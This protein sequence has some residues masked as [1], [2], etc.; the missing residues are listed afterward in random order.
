MKKSILCALALVAQLFATQPINAQIPIDYVW[1]TP[2]KNSSESM[3]CGGGSVGMNVWVENGTIFFY[4]CR[5]GSFD[6][7]NTILK[8]GRFRINLIPALKTDANFSQILHLSDGYVSVSDGE[9]TV[10]IWVDVFKPVIHVDIDGKQSLKV[11]ASYDNWRIEDKQLGDRER[12]QTSYK[13]SAPKGT[14]THR[15]SISA[16]KQSITFFHH[17]GKLT[18]FDATVAQQKMESV[19]TIMYN[20]LKNLTFGGEM[21]GNGFFLKGENKGVYADTPY[22]T[23]IYESVNAAK[24]QQLQITLASA[25][26]DI[27]QWKNE[28]EKT[29]TA[30]N[31]KKDK[32]ITRKWWKQYWK[33]SVI[34]G[35]GECAAITR[36]YTLF[37][38][39]LGCNAISEWPTKF[40]GGLLAFD[41]VY[42][43]KNNHFTPDYRNWGGGVHTM[44]N[45]RLVYWP[46]LKSG[47]Y[48][49]MK[50][51]FDFYLR[52]LGNAQLRSNVYWNHKGAAFTEQMENFGL[53]NFDEYGKKR[54]VGYDPGIQYNAWL[55]YTWDTALE[56]CEMILESE[57]YSN[58]NISEYIP[59]V[60]S[61]L[62]FFDEHY[63]YLAKLRGIKELDGDGK[64][65]IYPGSGAE[66]FKMAYNPTSTVAG[67]KVVTSSLI[68]YL[69]KHNS[70]SIS[71]NKYKE[72]LQ[73]IPDI[74]FREVDGHKILSPAVTWARVNNTEPTELYPVFPWHI[75]GVGKPDIKLAQDTYLYDP[76]ALK[77]RSHVGWKQDNI[78]AADLGLTD[79]AARL[80]Q[81]KLSDG[82]YRF[83]AFWGPGFDWSP[84][85][86]WG[87]SGMIGLQDMLLQEADGKIIIF[88]AWPKS[89]NVHFK[90][91]ATQKTTV[92][93]T[94][95]D[96]K[97]TELI[98][99]PKSR[100]KDVVSNIN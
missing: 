69:S 42:V 28:L 87:G 11:E 49:A 2:S 20:P 76:F 93:A 45:Q 55:E 83:P 97:I 36:N 32:D 86:N 10:N 12:F 23:W 99:S 27:P 44:Q 80:A 77:F 31:T 78:W 26:G 19:K 81:L 34:E 46:M 91:H 89:W 79:E 47:D 88:P 13:W 3:P 41:P 92:E 30:V 29:K 63:R 1:K 72:L 38:Y 96:G 54:P 21:S 37:R 74:S 90:L 52:I 94:L 95:K 6:E 82:P 65:I 75:Y 68:A 57:S 14:V 39:M 59:F 98:V 4:V 53:P 62:D 70:D 40:N 8:Q 56:F 15:D 43:D 16:D 61:T 51:Q 18:I 5:T 85:H 7:N 58:N 35:N 50:S 84:D 24:H 9:K 60:K 71:L 64:L 67:L 22:S 17:N 48:D 66:T 100:T 33:R 73:R 25:Q